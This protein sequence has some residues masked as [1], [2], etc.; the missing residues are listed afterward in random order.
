MNDAFKGSQ[1]GERPDYQRPQEREGRRYHGGYRHHHYD[2]RGGGRRFSHWQPRNKFAE[3]QPVADALNVEMFEELSPGELAQWAGKKGYKVEKEDRQ[4]IIKDILKA[5]AAKLGLKEAEGVVEYTRAGHAFLRLPAFAYQP[6]RDDPFIPPEVVKQHGLMNG[7]QICG[8]VRVPPYRERFSTVAHVDLLWDA[9]PSR[10][11]GRVPFDSMV[12]VHPDKRF[13]LESGPGFIDM[14]ALDLLAP[15]GRGQRCLLVAPPRAGKT[16]ML[17]HIAES[18]AKNDPDVNI[19]VMLIDERP[20]EAENMRRTIRGEVVCSTFD[21]DI[22]RHVRMSELVIE[23]AHRMLEVGKH[24]LVLVDSLTRMSRA[25]NNLSSS[26]GKLMSGGMESGAMTKPRKFFSS[27]RNIENGGSLTI[28]ATVL[29]ETGSRMDD[30]I[31]EEFKGTG[32][33][34]VYLNRDLQE[35]RLFPAIHIEKTGTRR[36]D[37]L[38]HP[39]EY[40]RICALRKQLT[41]Y[42]PLEAMEKLIEQLRLTKSNAELLMRLKVD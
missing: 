21:E 33:M 23:K 9:P 13:I 29:V 17:Q 30:L 36:E 1:P 15:L 5:H 25:Y 32:N 2:R 8:M 37:M 10:W 39:A 20:E 19:L 7:D 14:R 35:R 31:F 18:V 22:E 4:G 16:V 11:K 41:E 27:A 38:Y 26:K 3:H 40:Q 6:Q 12:P 34:E 42:P 28:V 24:V